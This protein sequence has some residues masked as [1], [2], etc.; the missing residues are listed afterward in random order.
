MGGTPFSLPSSSYHIISYHIIS[1][2]IMSYHIILARVTLNLTGKTVG[3]S[4]WRSAASHSIAGSY[5]EFKPHAS[6]KT[7]K[8]QGCHLRV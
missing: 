7:T 5:G 2:H 1:Y 3:S 8:E 4:F 6:V